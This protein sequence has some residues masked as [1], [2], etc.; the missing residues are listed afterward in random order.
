MFEG[1]SFD[2]LGVFHCSKSLYGKIRTDRIS[3]ENN[4]PYKP[5][6]R[7]Q[8]EQEKKRKTAAPWDGL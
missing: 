1:Q 7:T 8:T 4:E 3:K 2:I 6:N 5:Y